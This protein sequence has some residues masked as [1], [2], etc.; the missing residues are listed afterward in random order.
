MK[1]PD[2]GI[3]QKCIKELDVLPKDCLYVGDGGSSELEAA[4][5]LGMHSMQA[6]WYFKDG[7]NQQTKRKP[8]FQQAESPDDIVGK[9]QKSVSAEYL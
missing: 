7:V 6:T 8:E 9:I 5:L 1:K 3:F 4:R 2:K